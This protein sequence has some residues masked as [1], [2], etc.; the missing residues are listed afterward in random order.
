[1]PG[2]SVLGYT[3]IST[4]IATWRG[5]LKGSGGDVQHFADRFFAERGVRYGRGHICL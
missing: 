5:P 1:M 4:T 2:F 3:S